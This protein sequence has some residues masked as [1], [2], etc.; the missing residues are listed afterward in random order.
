MRRTLGERSQSNQSVRGAA[1]LQPRAQRVDTSQLDQHTAQV[2][3]HH[4][5]IWLQ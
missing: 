1:V 2:E 3:E 4:A 5:H